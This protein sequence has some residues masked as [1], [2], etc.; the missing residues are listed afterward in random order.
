MIRCIILDI[1]EDTEYRNEN[2]VFEKEPVHHRIGLEMKTRFSAFEDKR[3]DTDHT[4]PYKTDDKGLYP[5]D[6]PEVMGWVFW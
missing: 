5:T 3:I 4:S 6:A 1:K 2:K